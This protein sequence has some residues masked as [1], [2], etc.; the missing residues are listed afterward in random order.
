MFLLEFWSQQ[1][2]QRYQE[3]CQV[4]DFS[5]QGQLAKE[6]LIQSHMISLLFHERVI[7]HDLRRSSR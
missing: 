1:D 6:Y 4:I 2:F 3:I 7:L 5:E